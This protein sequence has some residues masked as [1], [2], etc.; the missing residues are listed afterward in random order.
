[1]FDDQKMCFPQERNAFYRISQ[2]EFPLYG[3]GLSPLYFADILNV[4]NSYI[5]KD[6]LTLLV[7]FSSFSVSCPSIDA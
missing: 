1:M 2:G 7:D 4:T 5:F 3:K 6:P